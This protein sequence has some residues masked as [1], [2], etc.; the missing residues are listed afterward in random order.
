MSATDAQLLL[1]AI[2][3]AIMLVSFRFQVMAKDGLIRARAAAREADGSLREARA[4]NDEVARILRLFSGVAD[5]GE[6]IRELWSLMHEWADSVTQERID[7]FEHEIDAKLQLLGF[8]T[9]AFV[10]GYC[11]THADGGRWRTMDTIGM[12][13]WTTDKRDAL[14]FSLRKHADAFA[15]DDPEDVRIVPV[16]GA[17]V[18]WDEAQRVCDLPDVDE[19]IRKLLDDST[20]DNATFMVRAILSAGCERTGV[21][22]C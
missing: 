19:A 18:Q 10:R 11:I 9:Q 1:V 22:A 2:T 20:G 7:H 12:P 5:R 8:A 13:D 4:A 14:C 15:A 16:A 6:I 21:A 3:L 17:P